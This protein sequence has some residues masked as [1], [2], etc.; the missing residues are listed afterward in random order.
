MT[1]AGAVSLRKTDLSTTEAAGR[2]PAGVFG[3]A[4]GRTKDFRSNVKNQGK[5]ANWTGNIPHPQLP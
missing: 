4:C 3:G 1:K 2:W 5:L